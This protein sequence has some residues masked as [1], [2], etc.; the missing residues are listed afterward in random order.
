MALRNFHTPK[1]ENLYTPDCIRTY[2][3]IYMNVFE[4]TSDMID[5]EDIAHSLSMQPRFSGHLK[6]FYSVAQ[7]C[8][9][10]AEKMHESHQ[11]EALLHDASEAYLL[12]I[13]S[14]IKNRLQGYKDIEFK[15]MEVIA[16]EFGFTMP[17]HEKVKE[18][19]NYML[20]WEW[21]TLM[22]SKTILPRLEYWS[23]PIAEQQ[24]MEA[25]FKYKK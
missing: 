6:G 20:Q 11:L 8:V 22:L 16:K 3:G 7:H 9:I 5:I 10:M 18:L 21:S 1:D 24:F 12:D 25:Y 14:P 17:L 2:R 13:A 4:P 15:L 19:D 23:Q